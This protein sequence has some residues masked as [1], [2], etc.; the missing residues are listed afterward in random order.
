MKISCIAGLGFT[1]LFGAAP[2]STHAQGVLDWS[3]KAQ[4]ICVAT[5]TSVVSAPQAIYDGATPYLPVNVEFALKSVLGSGTL[6][7]TFTVAGYKGGWIS[8]TE[9]P[10][11]S[12]EYH[13]YFSSFQ[14]GTTYLL[15]LTYAPLFAGEHPRD[16]QWRLASGGGSPSL[17][18]VSA[19]A[20][21]HRPV[22]SILADVLNVLNA[23]LN[24]R[25]SVVQDDAI[26]A[27]GSYGPYLYDYKTYPN[28][29]YTLAGPARNLP[30]QQNVV[31]ALKETTIPE[32]LQL[33]K[34][35][36]PETVVKLKTALAFLQTPDV[37]PD[38]I[39][40][41]STDKRL[42]WDA[43]LYALTTFGVPGAIPY[44]SKGAGDN[45]PDT[46][47]ACIR[48]LSNMRDTRGEAALIQALVKGTESKVRYNAYLALVGT[49][50]QLDGDYGPVDFA[51]HEK[52]ID[53]FWRDWATKNNIPIP[54][55]TTALAPAG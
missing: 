46:A 54:P 15:F 7:N 9:R 28:M 3:N 32:L 4:I 37:I 29:I 30:D 51:A 33:E 26:A 24:D 48:A 34:T 47:I 14:A 50:G 10:I 19:S 42:D 40:D 55:S 36:D 49:T 2:L 12:F 17:V 21:A 38:V 1:L 18:A 35:S 8:P 31:N 45:N 43:P 16:L 13:V 25:S 6:P 39:A 41:C 22:A 53:Q 23:S 11:G 52:E 44:L 20:L 5:A 27:I